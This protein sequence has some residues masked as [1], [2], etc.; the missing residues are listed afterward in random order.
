[1]DIL[2][3]KRLS[4]LENIC[5][6]YYNNSR[7]SQHLILSGDI[8]LNPGPDKV[9]DKNATAVKRNKA[10]KCPSCEKAVQIN[11]KRFLCEVCYDPFHAECTGISEY[12]DLDYGSQF[13]VRG[14][15][16]CWYGGFLVR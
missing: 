6:V 15:P 4:F 9:E 3:T 7:A 13:L 1:L 10:P 11:H 14:H 5:T 2:A 16:I 8:A 12:K